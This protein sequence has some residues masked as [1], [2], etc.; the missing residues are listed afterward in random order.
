VDEGLCDTY[1]ELI[2][3]ACNVISLS[4]GVA[5]NDEVELIKRLRAA[6]Q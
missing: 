1:R 6:L 3:E 2:L 5:E 4:D